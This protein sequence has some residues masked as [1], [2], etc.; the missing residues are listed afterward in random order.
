MPTTPPKSNFDLDLD[1]GN[2]WEDR[3]C[4]MLEGE[5]SVEVK[6]DKMWAKT[7]NLAFEYMRYDMQFDDEILTGLL[8]TK[9]HWWCNILCHA[10]NPKTSSGIRIWETKRIK[11]VLSL[12]LEQGRAWVRKGIGDGGRT[13]I[14]VAPVEHLCETKLTD[15]T[16]TKEI[17]RR[18]RLFHEKS[19][20][21]EGELEA[22]R[23]L[24]ESLA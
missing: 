20:S 8:D 2:F 16:V 22:C 14:I 18:R 1:F 10:T 9:A 7:G 17:A 21:A 13:S 15:Y 12:L 23:L 19:Y 11:Y 24:K 3:I 6:A 5:G 4:R